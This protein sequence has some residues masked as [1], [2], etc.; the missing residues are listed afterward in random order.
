MANF[1][2]KIKNS[3]TELAEI[4]KFL[5]NPNSF[6]DPNF[7]EKSRRAAEIR[8]ILDI[9]SK[10]K[11]LQQDLKGAEAIISSDES[12]DLIELAKAEKEDLE[13]SIAKEE[14]KLKGLLVPKDPND[15]KSAVLEIRAGAG[16]DEAGLFAQELLRMYTRWCDNHNLKYELLSFSSSDNGGLREAILDIKSKGSYGSL[17]YESGVHRVQ[18]IPSTESAGRIHTSTATVAVMPEVQENEIHIDP[19]DITVDVFRSGG[20]GGQSVNTTDSAVRITHKPSGLVV[21]CQDQKSQLKNRDK[22]MQVLRSR[23]AKIELDKQNAKMDAARK[24]LVGSGDRS[25]KVRTYNY[26]QDRITDHRIGFSRSNLVGFMDG[27][28]DEMLTKL[29]SAELDIL[30]LS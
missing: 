27:G 28:I 22:A 25:E 16:G 12:Y 21:T 13:G 20:N 1:E 24:S 8:D 11:S 15:N 6:S 19:S 26:P 18:R 7:G 14:L 4:D 29:N 2:Q 3:E 10:I 17:K 30:S 23:L 5:S 9:D